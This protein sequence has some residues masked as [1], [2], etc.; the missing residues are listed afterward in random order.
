MDVQES[1]LGNKDD[2]SSEL[3]GAHLSALGEDVWFM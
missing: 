2:G 1:E 3:C